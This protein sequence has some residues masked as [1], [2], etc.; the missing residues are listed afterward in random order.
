MIVD[1]QDDWK[2][3][4][5]KVSKRF[6]MEADIDA[7]LFLIGIQEYGKIPEKLS[8][9][10]KL[11]MMHIAICSLLSEYGYYTYVGDDKDGWPHWDRNKKLPNLSDEEQDQLIKQAIL[12]YFSEL[13]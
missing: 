2:I 4:I 7:I 1:L 13:D 5:A 3:L 10:Q 9:D 8:K 6:E 11:E 12:S